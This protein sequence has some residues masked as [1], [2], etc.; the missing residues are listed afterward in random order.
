MAKSTKSPNPKSKVARP[1][2]GQLVKNIHHNMK[3]INKMG[4]KRG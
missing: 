3:R 1:K 4:G 2:R